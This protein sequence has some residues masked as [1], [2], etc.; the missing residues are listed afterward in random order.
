MSGLLTAV[1]EDKH[2]SDLIRKTFKQT[3][4]INRTSKSLGYVPEHAVVVVGVRNKKGRKACERCRIKKIKCGGEPPCKRCKDDGQVCSSGRRKKTEVKQLPRGYADVLENTQYAPITTVQ[5][6][7]NMIRNNKS[8]DLWEPDLD[9]RGRPDIHDI[10]SLLGCI[11]PSEDPPVTFPEGV[12]D[13]A[14]LKAQLRVA[15]VNDTRSRNQYASSP[16]SPSHANTGRDSV[17]EKDQ[18]ILSTDYNQTWAQQQQQVR[19]EIH[20]PAFT[21]WSTSDNFFG[22]PHALNVT[23]Q[24]KLAQ[25]F[26]NISEPILEGLPV[27]RMGLVEHNLLNAMQIQDGL[28]FADGTISPHMLNCNGY[29][30][31]SQMDTTTFGRG[32]ESWLQA[33][34]PS[35]RK[36]KL[37]IPRDENERLQQEAPSIP[38][39][40]I[41]EVQ[42]LKEF[43]CAT[44][45]GWGGG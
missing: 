6:L 28:N 43:Y 26:P 7:Y 11:R 17:T 23:A 1:V 15:H 25:P 18:S 45:S 13:F 41:E 33:Q 19:G 2:R 10:A 20:W 9:E 29:D 3:N 44:D 42:R 31:S 12:E 30:P 16:P 39:Y 36:Q 32:Y 8:W 21:T 40:V 24:F 35:S 14:E 4:P 34:L 5:K 22:P 37:S 27:R 38:T